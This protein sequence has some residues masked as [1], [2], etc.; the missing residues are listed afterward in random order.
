M[1]VNFFSCVGADAY[2][3]FTHIL[4][5]YILI[6]KPIFLQVF[7]AWTEYRKERTRL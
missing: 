6:T 1:N 2:Q 5:I 7:S 4:F 3:C